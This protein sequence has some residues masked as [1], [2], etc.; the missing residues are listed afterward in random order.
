[1]TG[2]PRPVDRRRSRPLLNLAGRRAGTSSTATWGGLVPAEVTNNM[3]ESC[4][5]PGHD[6]EA[7]RH[8]QV[9]AQVAAIKAEAMRRH[10]LEVAALNNAEFRLHYDSC[11]SCQAA[12]RQARRE[13][14]PAR[15]ADVPF[16]SVTTAACPAGGHLPAK[17]DSRGPGTTS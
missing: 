8:Q 14:S 3:P 10:D 7:A 9:R 16:P 12:R 17:A 5:R 6:R 13:N 15:G 11:T 4:Y 2:T 1:V